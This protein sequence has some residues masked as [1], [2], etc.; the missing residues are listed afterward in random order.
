MFGC[1]Q[2]YNVQ[3]SSYVLFL[4]IIISDSIPTTTDVI[5][6]ANRIA[7]RTLL[8]LWH[9]KQ[10][11]P[12]T[13]NKYPNSKTSILKFDPLNSLT[14]HIE[15]RLRSTWAPCMRSALNMSDACPA[16]TS[17][18]MRFEQSCDDSSTYSRYECC[19]V[20]F[21]SVF[22]LFIFCVFKDLCLFGYCMKKRVLV[23]SVTLFNLILHRS[24][25][26]FKSGIVIKIPWH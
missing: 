9:I 25:R 10:W 18:R 2:V 16:S 1:A 19:R 3:H 21:V 6:I 14:F 20:R 22:Y 8:I 5:C 24:Q 12:G 13:S 23:Y 11:A 4:Q 17:I 26:L 7:Q 15:C